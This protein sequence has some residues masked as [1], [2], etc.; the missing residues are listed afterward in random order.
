MSRFAV[1][2]AGLVLCANTVEGFVAPQPRA[3]AN[4]EQL[5]ATGQ[6]GASAAP[7]GRIA[8]LAIAAL[9]AAGATALVAGRRTVRKP[10]VPVVV[11]NAFENETG[12]QAP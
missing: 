12:V 2:A 8:P 3:P 5:R 7:E 11:A 10:S 6:S 4:H 9:G 1:T